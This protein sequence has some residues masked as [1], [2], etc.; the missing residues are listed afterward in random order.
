MGAEHNNRARPCTASQVLLSSY[1]VLNKTHQL[2]SCLTAA[3]HL[4]AACCTGRTL[5]VGLASTE[6][7][8]GSHTLFLHPRCVPTTVSMPHPCRIV[9][10]SL[11]HPGDTSTLHPHHFISCCI[12]AASLLRP[13]YAPATKFARHLCSP[14]CIPA[15]PLL[16]PHCITAA[17]PRQQ[18]MGKG[19]LH[20]ALLHRG[21]A[22]AGEQRPRPPEAVHRIPAN[23]C[24]QQ[25][26][27]GGCGA[28][29]C[30]CAGGQSASAR[31]PALQESRGDKETA[32]QAD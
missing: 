30:G 4:C 16:H 24:Q 11:L 23:R 6:L 15:A 26:C 7:C 8:A 5:L 1:P 12:P 19:H 21:V 25:P 20:A 14:C 18:C 27:A 28:I 22:A 9:P 13:C 10:T 29:S 3:C 17:S 2:P 32:S 31:R